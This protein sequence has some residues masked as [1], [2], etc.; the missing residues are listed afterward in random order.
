MTDPLLLLILLLGGGGV[1]VWAVIKMRVL[2][3]ELSE[4]LQ[5][6]SNLQLENSNLR[7]ALMSAEVS[8]NAYRERATEAGDK[9]DSVH[10]Q[11]IESRETSTARI[12]VLEESENTLSHEVAKL[13]INLDEVSA[14]AKHQKGRAQSAHT[15]K[16]Q[17]VEKWA[18]FVDH[19]ALDPNWRPEDWAFLGNPIDY[20]VFDWRRKVEEN[21]EEGKVYILEVKSAESTLS[22]KQRRIRDLVKA[23]KVE[24][25]EIRLD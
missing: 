1:G 25:R 2:S 5:M 14:E 10:N 21:L 18:P 23:G 22:T 12:A 9:L 4:I 16:G 6:E 15:A 13:S 19:P 7:I 11:M 17:L 8:E 24:W 20:M 3:A